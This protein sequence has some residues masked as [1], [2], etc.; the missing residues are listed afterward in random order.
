[1]DR[2]HERERRAAAEELRAVRIRSAQDEGYAA[3]LRLMEG[4]FPPEERRS[5]PQHRRALAED[6]FHCLLLREEGQVAGLLTYWRHRDFAFVEHLAVNPEQRG[7]GLGHRIMH[8][9]AEE[10]CPGVPVILE[11]EPVCD[12]MTARRLRFYESCGFVRLPDAHVQ[13]PYHAGGSPL[14][15]ELLL[16][17]CGAPAVCPPG[18]EDYVR[19]HVMQYVDR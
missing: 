3:L 7:R 8:L 12:E 16:H 11:I 9:L 19:G 15:M 18:F 10:L 6:D 13:L 17:P 4:S 5:E 1:M 2:V 14:P